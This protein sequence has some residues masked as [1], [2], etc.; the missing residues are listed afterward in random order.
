ME[1]LGY[2]VIPNYCAQN[3][4]AEANQYV[5]GLPAITGFT[6]FAHQ[7]IRLLNQPADLGLQENGTAIVIHDFQL[8][9]GHPRCPAYMKDENGSEAASIVE[10]FKADLRI[11]LII[12]IDSEDDA[13]NDLIEHHF[14]GKRQN[15]E[16]RYYANPALQ[17]RINHSF[18]A[19][20]HCVKT[21]KVRF[22]DSKKLSDWLKK[23]MSPGYFI[24]DRYDLL[25][26][27]KA[28]G[29]T[30]LDSVL[31]SMTR[32]KTDISNQYQRSR[33]GW[34]IPVAIGYQAIEQPQQRSQARGGHPHV[35]AEP[36]TGLAEAVSA[37]RIANEEKRLTRQ[38]IFW[39]HQYQ[40]ENS[41]YYVT[42]LTGV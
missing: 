6:G 37:K 40:V 27:D 41:L 15:D 34:I 4:N 42:A 8:R 1:T 26:E 24:K 30:P 20:G 32:F 31:N 3:V 21:G 14:L 39:T 22:F 12:R 38:A 7:Q 9:A 36:V 2:L 28:Q 35:Y 19:G 25:S 18:L 33:K 17:N 23:E 16:T 29:I 13:A 11:S 5:V 10:E